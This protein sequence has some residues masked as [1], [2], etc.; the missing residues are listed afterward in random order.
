VG[1]ERVAGWWVSGWGEQR[2]AHQ[3]SGLLDAVED[4]AGLDGVDLGYR[5]DPPALVRHDSED[6]IAEPMA[7]SNTP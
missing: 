5:R 2:A 3:A 7:A 1:R 4:G 6:W